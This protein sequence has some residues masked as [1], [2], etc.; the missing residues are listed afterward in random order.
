MAVRSGSRTVDV[1]GNSDMSDSGSP[2]SFGNVQVEGED[3]AKPT[4]MTANDM[5]GHLQKFDWGNHVPGTPGIYRR[6]RKSYPIGIRRRGPG[7]RKRPHQL[8]FKLDFTL[9]YKY[10]LIW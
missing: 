9:G 6:I 3:G 10:I 4:S 1:T 5:T 8:V 2:E 7:K